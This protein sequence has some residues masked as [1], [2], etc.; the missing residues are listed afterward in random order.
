MW[1]FSYYNKLFFV[2]SELQLKLLLQC[3]LTYFQNYV[4]I[5]FIISM[6]KILNKMGHC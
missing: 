5:L 6:S 4:Y 2:P 1:V 3:Y